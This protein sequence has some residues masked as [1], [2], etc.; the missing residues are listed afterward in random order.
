M[1][2]RI[3]TDHDLQTLAAVAD[4]YRGMWGSIGAPYECSFDG[5]IIDIDALDF[6]DYEAGYHPRD[7]LG[8]SLIWGNVLVSTGVLHWL[9]NTSGQHFVGSIDYP[10]LL[11]W[12]YARVVEITHTIGPQSGKYRW[13][14]QQA[15]MDCLSRGDFSLD[16]NQKLVELLAPESYGGFNHFAVQAIQ[17]ILNSRKPA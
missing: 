15:V 4:E 8:S 7:E 9:I 6:V 1:D 10:R 13:L 3:A 11:L 5:A 17:Q 16:E 2:L 12:P 14:L